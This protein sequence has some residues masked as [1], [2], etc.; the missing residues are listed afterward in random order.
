MTERIDGGTNSPHWN[1]LPTATA[2]ML[3]WLIQNRLLTR[4]RPYFSIKF[5]SDGLLART[6]SCDLVDH[7]DPVICP[8]FSKNDWQV[9]R[10]ARV[11]KSMPLT[12]SRPE[13]LAKRADVLHHFGHEDPVVLASLSCD[14]S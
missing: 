3:V 14:Q 10:T 9:R 2:T 8:R 11:I 4:R 5:F 1:Q 12:L 13:Q 6:S 7:L